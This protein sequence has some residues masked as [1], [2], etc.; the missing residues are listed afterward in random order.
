M[1]SVFILLTLSFVLSHTEL[2]YRIDIAKRYNNDIQ[3]DR[4]KM[5]ACTFQ[6]LAVIDTFPASSDG[7]NIKPYL[8]SSQALNT[9]YSIFQDEKL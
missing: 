1:D 3:P 5:N 8:A 7:V 6:A 4:S 9:Q 2:V